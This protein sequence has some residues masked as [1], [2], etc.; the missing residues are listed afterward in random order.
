MYCQSQ[1]KVA[2]QQKI[3]IGGCTVILIL[4]AKDITN[5]L[6]RLY[7]SSHEHPSDQQHVGDQFFVS[8]LRYSKMEDQSRGD[9]SC[10]RA[11]KTINQ[12]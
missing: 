11:N 6:G 1:W 4:L 7:G 5:L 9:V 2:G 3:E 10:M 8:Y 12:Y